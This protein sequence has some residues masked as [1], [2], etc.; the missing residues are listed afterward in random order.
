M[1]MMTLEGIGISFGDKAL[2]RNVTQGIED[3]D[4]IGVIG[5]NGTGKST[6]LAIVAG[7][8]QADEGQIISRKGLKISYLPQNPVFRSDR[9]VLE[10][11]VQN[12]SQDQAFWNVQGEASAMLQKLGIDDPSV[13]PD[14]LS[15]GQRKRAALAAALLTPSDLLILDEPTNHLDHEMIEWLQN[16]L[17]SYKGAILMITHDRYFLDEVTSTIWEIDR[18]GVYSY[19]G[20]YE[21]YLQMKQERMDFARA[22]ERKMAAIYK[23]DLAWMMRGARARSTK[24]KAHIQRFEALR[25]REKIAEERNVILES[26]PSRMGNKTIEVRNLAKSYGDKLLFRDFSYT[27]LKNDRIGIIGPN[28]CGKSTL[29]KILTGEVLPDQ[30]EVEIGQTI[31][32]SYFGQ[33]NEELPDS[34]TVIDMVK[35]T[36]EYV[37]TADGLITASAMCERFLFIKSKQYTPVAKLSG[38]EKRRLY[39]LR[40]LMEAPNVLILDVPTNDLDIQTLQILEDYLDHFSGIVIAVSHDRYFLDR[41][42]NRIFSFE[43][44][45]LLHQSEGGYEEY[46]AHKEGLGSEEPADGAAADPDPAEKTGKRQKGRSAEPR[47]RLSY[48]QQ[49]EYDTIEGVIDELTE[50]SQKLAEEMLQVST[51]YVKLQE[52]SEEKQRI[53]AELEERIERYL[54]LQEL[55]ESFQQ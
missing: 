40:V 21:K 2:L 14:T 43:G 10:N 13:M 29:L 46:L 26:L 6:L 18:V 15:G 38:G 8:L 16:Q 25:D 53:D 19:P 45:G 32:I 37:R 35:E 24:Q 12:I 49:R 27:F 39:L 33:E 52:F 1:I 22:A 17:D 41:V 42:V 34:G 36:G 55:V 3:Y 54:E 50:K 31:R 23:Q 48:S 4:R 5:I 30:G 28:G 7:T 11:V 9:S 47:K 51:D 44:D 20:N